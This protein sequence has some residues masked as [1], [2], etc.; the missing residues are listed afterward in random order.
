MK[1]SSNHN[2]VKIKNR[3]PLFTNN[4]NST[5]N[6]DIQHDQHQSRVDGIVQ[7]ERKRSKIAYPIPSN[8]HGKNSS[9]VKPTN[10]LFSKPISQ[11]MTI[12][13]S[14]NVQQQ[15]TCLETEGPRPGF[16]KEAID[17]DGSLNVRR[18][19]S[20]KRALSSDHE[21]TNSDRKDIL[22]DEL[23]WLP[24]VKNHDNCSTSKRN[25][26]IVDTYDIDT[27]MSSQDSFADLFA[28]TT[29]TPVCTPQ[30]SVP[31][32]EVF[33]SQSD[34]N[35][36]CGG[37]LFSDLFDDDD[38]KLAE[39]DVSGIILS[40]SSSCKELESQKTQSDTCSEMEMEINKTN[41]NTACKT[42]KSSHT[43]KDP[44]VINSSDQKALQKVKA[45][46][47]NVNTSVYNQGCNNS[48]HAE[49]DLKTMNMLDKRLPVQPVNT[50]VKN[51]DTNRQ[52]QA[53][54]SCKSTGN[55]KNELKNECQ[56]KDT[57]E[58]LF[59]GLPPKVGN[60]I[61]KHKGIEKLY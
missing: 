33:S 18:K 47:K 24:T 19:R 5:E 15:P 48:S 61:K 45:N 28:S 54:I 55:M 27:G 41:S 10:G 6:V 53:D 20:N 59:Y 7:P 60:L 16:E 3:R 34:C 29:N 31:N 21:K 44:K 43:E 36:K 51:V 35:L 40:Y 46:D 42:Y 9:E 26:N 30:S 50:D 23:L 38:S 56:A 25:N 39:L 32:S 12:T 11:S 37:N 58:E 22:D 49:K 17:S 52:N 1:S 13:A 2:H 14:K 57:S 4:K 8:F